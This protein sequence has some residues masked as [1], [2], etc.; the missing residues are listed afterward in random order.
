MNQS[1]LFAVEAVDHVI[2][3]RRSIRAFLDQPIP[4]E[5][6]KTI[7]KVASRAPS[8]SNTQ[9]WKVYVARGQTRQQIIDQVC[10]AQQQ[11]NQQP[12]LAVNYQASFAYYPQKWFSPYIERRR[13]N[14]LGLYGLLGILKG[15]KDKMAAQHL[16]NYQLFDA[17]VVMFLTVHQ[18]LGVGAKMDA[19]MLM[20]NIMLAAKARG[21]DSCPQAA[22]NHF[23]S[24]VLPLLQA[25]PE[26]ELVCAIA[27][28][29]ADPDAVVNQFQTPR[30]AVDEFSVFLD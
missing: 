15:E 2:T 11:L 17:P 8:G 3:S 14:G 22:W 16:R 20:Q 10:Q 24:L 9:P 21:I 19:S 27:L 13:E 7:L 29:Y 4:E 26:E 18:D 23:H 5:T 12:E 1:H 25:S 6:L 28:G 30:A